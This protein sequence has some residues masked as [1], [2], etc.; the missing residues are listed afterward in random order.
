[1]RICINFIVNKMIRRKT[2]AA[3]YNENNFHEIHKVTSSFDLFV[4]CHFPSP[5]VAFECSPKKK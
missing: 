3:R 1:M 4:Q 2:L 5:R